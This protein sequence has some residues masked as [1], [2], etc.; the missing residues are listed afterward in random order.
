[1]KH[2]KNSDQFKMIIK[3]KK[4]YLPKSINIDKLKYLFDK[5]SNINRYIESGEEVPSELSKNFIS[6]DLSDN[7]YEGL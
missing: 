4:L 5:F 2:I 1:M 3:E 6:F 7:P